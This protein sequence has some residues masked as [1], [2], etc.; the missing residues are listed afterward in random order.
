MNTQ[1]HTWL[2]FAA[3]SFAI[4][5][6]N[7][8]NIGFLLLGLVPALLL[9]KKR[10]IF[11]NRHF[12][13]SATLALI[14]ILPNLIWQLNNEFPV[15]THFRTLSETQLVNVSR[16]DF[17]VDQ[18][19]FFM[20]SFFVILFGFISFFTLKKF[21]DHRW[22]FLTFVITIGIFVVMRGKNYY[23]VGLYPV[24]IAFGA[25]YLERLLSKGWLKYLRVPA[26]LIPFI[27]FILVARLILPILPP[28]EIVAQQELFDKLELTRWEDGKLH[29]LP[30]D[31]AD[32]LGWKELAGII[33]CALINVDEKDRTIIHCDNYGQAGA[34]NFYSEELVEPAVSM[35]ADYIN[36]YPLEKFEIKNVILVKD[37]YDT[38]QNREKER[39]LFKEVSLIGEIKNKYAREAGTKVY[40][41]K[42]AKLPINDIFKNEILKRKNVHLN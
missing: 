13:L 2:Y 26:M 17:L 5:F 18:V 1:R 3:V 16:I 33:D 37:I 34:I 10:T 38:D 30:Q 40:L 6:L 19:Y 22:L 21:R 41:L 12:Y 15:I 28:S 25:V 4:G 36:W 39:P 8:Y 9:T 42:G 11:L 31:Y 7:K 14:I 23:A 32:M 35:N 24:I 20:G 27:V 29:E